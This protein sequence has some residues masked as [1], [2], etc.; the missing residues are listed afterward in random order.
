MHRIAIAQLAFLAT[1]VRA[2]FPYIPTYACDQFHG[3]ADQDKRAL[4]AEANVVRDA[5]PTELLTLK[6]AQRV[7][8]VRVWTSRCHR[9]KLTQ[10]F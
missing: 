10:S 3:C 8:P 6:L 4:P 5:E 1:F 9:L 7:S 2:F